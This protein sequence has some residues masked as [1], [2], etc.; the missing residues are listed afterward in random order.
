MDTQQPKKHVPPTI[1]PNIEWIMA[2]NG[3]NEPSIAVKAGST[4]SILASE[5]ISS[6]VQQRLL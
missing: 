4:Q 1:M 3:E 5:P 2:M 6:T